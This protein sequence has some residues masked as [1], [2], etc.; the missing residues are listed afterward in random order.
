L[1]QG[2]ENAKAYLAENPELTFEIENLIRQEAGLSTLAEFE[3]LELA[4]A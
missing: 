2:R 3:N 4:A 1:G